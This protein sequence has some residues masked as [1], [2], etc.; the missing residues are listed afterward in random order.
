MLFSEYPTA[1]AVELGRYAAGRSRAEIFVRDS[2]GG[3]VVIS[4]AAETAEHPA[5]KRLA[6]RFSGGR[7][8]EAGGQWLFHVGLWTPSDYRDEFLA[9]YEVEHLPLLLECPLWDGC[10]FVEETVPNGCQFHALHQ[11]SDTKA[12]DAEQRKRS[13]ST[14]WFNRLAKNDWFDGAFKRTLYR[15]VS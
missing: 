11:L 5:G 8:G 9:W 10:R 2:G 3:A 14:P 1:D 7:F 6:P 4:D 12:L 13:R 15:R